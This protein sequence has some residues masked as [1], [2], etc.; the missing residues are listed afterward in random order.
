M[1]VSPASICCFRND[2]TMQH[3]HTYSQK[4]TFIK[5]CV[6]VFYKNVCGKPETLKWGLGGPNRIRISFVSMNTHLYQSRLFNIPY[7]YQ[8]G[9][10]YIDLVIVSSWAEQLYVKKPRNSALNQEAVRPRSF[11]RPMPWGGVTERTC[12]PDGLCSAQEGT[13]ARAT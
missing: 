9:V 10:N 6:S 12:I 13:A 4:R 2:R 1:K 3:I 7:S 11:R 5:H 8:G